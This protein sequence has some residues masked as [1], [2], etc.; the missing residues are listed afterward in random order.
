MLS[1]LKLLKIKLEEKWE[2]QALLWTFA[3]MVFFA[4]T[5]FNFN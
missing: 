5:S 1:I 4:V 3:E 2:V